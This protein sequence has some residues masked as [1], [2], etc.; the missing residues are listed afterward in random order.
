MRKWSPIW[1]PTCFNPCFLGTCPRIVVLLKTQGL[2]WEFQSLF[3]WNLPS[4]AILPRRHGRTES[5]SILVFLELA[6]GCQSSW[7]HWGSVLGVSIL[8]FL[9]LALGSEIKL[10]P[11]RLLQCFNPCFLGTCPRISHLCRP[12][13]GWVTVSILVFL[14]LALGWE[15]DYSQVPQVVFQSLFSWNLPSDAAYF[16]GTEGSTPRFNPCFLGTCPRISSRRR[17]PRQLFGFQSLFSWNLPSDSLSNGGCR[18]ESTVSILVFLELALG[19]EVRVNRQRRNT[20]FQSLFSWNLPSDS[21][22]LQEHCVSR[23]VS[24]LVFLEL[25]LGSLKEILMHRSFGV[26][27]LVFLE[28]ALGYDAGD[29]WRSPPT[30]FQ[31]LFSWNLPSDNHPN[32]SF[33]RSMSVSI[34]VFLELALGWYRRICF[35]ERFLRFNPC[36]LGTCPRIFAFI[37]LRFPPSLFQSL[38]SWN[39]PSDSTF[40]PPEITARF[41]FNPCFL[42]TCPRMI[43]T[44]LFLRKVFAFQSLFSWNLPSDVRGNA[45]IAEEVIGFNPCFLGTCPRIPDALSMAVFGVSFNPCFLGTCPR[46]GRWDVSITGGILFQSLFSWNLPSDFG[47]CF[48]SHTDNYSFNPCFLGTCPRMLFVCLKIAG[49]TWFQSLFSWNLPSD[50]REQPRYSGTLRVSILVFLELALGCRYRFSVPG[51]WG[52]S[53]LVFLELALGSAWRF[54]F[55]SSRA[56][57]NPCF[58]GTCPRIVDI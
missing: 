34:L 48:S 49:G 24:I 46:I 27:I 29:A 47:V 16:I 56:G 15:A 38:F 30:Q 35:S 18:T 2:I 31:S 11:T 54:M 32:Y 6:L 1:Y 52:V 53:I 57:F 12:P 22:A 25:A 20:K 3:S 55:A 36:F 26:S 44:D 40:A 43:P 17:T 14:E 28:L 41:G 13:S 10:L 50:S 4:D 51:W 8:V 42:G 9:E 33:V 19:S 21:T 5:V 37:H 39:L 7:V 45:F 58:L 23:A